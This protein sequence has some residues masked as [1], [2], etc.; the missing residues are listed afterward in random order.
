ML[1]KLNTFALIGIDGVLVEVDTAAGLP[2][3]VLAGMKRP[4][5]EHDAQ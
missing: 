5:M 2:K 4:L 3:V 1:A